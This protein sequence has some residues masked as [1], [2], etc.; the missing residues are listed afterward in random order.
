MKNFY[1]TIV[2]MFG[3]IFCVSCQSSDVDPVDNGDVVEH[4]NGVQQYRTSLIQLSQGVLSRSE[5]EE[6]SEEEIKELV[7][8]SRIFLEQNDITNEDLDLN[9]NDELIAVVA[10]FLMDYQKSII[11]AKLSRTSPGGC[12][13]EAL[14][15][16]DLATGSLKQIA[17]TAAKVAV[18]RFTPYVGW[19]LFAWDY[20][21]CITE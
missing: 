10:L 19:G 9:E 21:S 3:M 20:I 1:L 2:A 12:L 8:V 4:L 6:P 14:A 17:K 15:I 11:N 13:I 18:K 7:E 16:K 5:N